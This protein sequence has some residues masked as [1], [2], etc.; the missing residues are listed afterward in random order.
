VVFTA[1]G[2]LG[3]LAPQILFDPTGLTLSSASAQ[4]ELRAVYFA[5]FGGTGA[6]LWWA[7]ARPR[8]QRR[9][10]RVL[11]VVLAGFVVG[12]LVSIPLDGP[13][14]G[15]ALLNLVVECVGLVAAVWLTPPPDA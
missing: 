7:V 11:S 12:R 2:G 9:A 10:L 1:V 4:A 8:Y 15:V 6:L 5:L 13:P 14:Q 3:L